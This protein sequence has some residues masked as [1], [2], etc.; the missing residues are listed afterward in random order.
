MA[1][2]FRRKFSRK[3]CLSISCLIFFAFALAKRFWAHDPLTLVYDL[4]DLQRIWHWEVKSGHYPSRQRS[5]L[6]MIY[7][8]EWPPK[9]TLI[10]VPDQLRLKTA[11]ENPALPRRRMS[12]PP[13]QNPYA[14]VTRGTGAKRIYLDIQSSPENSAYPPRP[15]PGSV[16]DLDIVM[17]HCDFSKKKVYC[18]TLYSCY[19][20]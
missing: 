4:E 19:C 18:D 17:D 6:F 9:F 13:H 7:T 2:F 11:P 20:Y 15:V 16:A 12:E 10:P 1:L 8:G 3:L 14:T 5:E